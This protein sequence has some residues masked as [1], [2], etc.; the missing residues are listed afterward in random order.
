[1]GKTP[2]QIKSLLYTIIATEIWGIVVFCL[3]G[4]ILEV[5]RLHVD[6]DL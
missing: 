2:P 4:L 5:I 6:L 1:M 3:F